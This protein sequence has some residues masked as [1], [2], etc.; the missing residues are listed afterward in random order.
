VTATPSPEAISALVV[1]DEEPLR[2]AL[3]QYLRYRGYRVLLADSGVAA[4]K[5]LRA[6]GV[7]L[8]LLDVRMPGMSG[9]DVV[10]R[11]WT[12]TPSSRS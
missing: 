7:D 2:S 1:D 4:L 12:S 3:G 9:V 11:R 5:Q 6:G 8:M 10:P